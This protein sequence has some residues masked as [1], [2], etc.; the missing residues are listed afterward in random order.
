MFNESYP[1]TNGKYTRSGGI[2]PQY[3]YHEYEEELESELARSES[4][5]AKLE[6]RAAELEKEYEYYRSLE[7]WV[8]VT[9]SGVRLELLGE[10]DLMIPAYL[11]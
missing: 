8:F 9:S 3:L 6:A 5:I 7:S 11:I 1:N 2:N 10:D 4:S